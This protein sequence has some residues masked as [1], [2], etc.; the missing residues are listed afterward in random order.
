LAKGDA[1]SIALLIEVSIWPEHFCQF[2]TRMDAVSIVCEVR[3]KDSG[4]ASGKPLH[5]TSRIGQ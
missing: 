1:E 5:N 2:V 4:M 3:H